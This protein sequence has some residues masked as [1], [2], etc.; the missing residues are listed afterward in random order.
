MNYDETFVFVT[1]Y[2]SHLYP[3]SLQI[4]A[5]KCTHTSDL[6]DVSWQFLPSAKWRSRGRC[7]VR[8]TSAS[9]SYRPDVCP[10]R[11]I[12][13]EIIVSGNRSVRQACYVLLLISYITQKRDEDM[14]EIFY[15]WIMLENLKFCAVLGTKI[16]SPIQ[17]CK[18]SLNN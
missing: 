13:I 2:Y 11:N 3:A 8:I 14:S 9:V 17:W 16:V 18:I 5:R 4:N 1:R 15:Q 10:R 6:A 12:F 7:F